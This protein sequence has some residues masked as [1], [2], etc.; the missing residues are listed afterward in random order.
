MPTISELV[1]HLRLHIFARQKSGLNPN[2]S[3]NAIATR[4][5]W[6]FEWSEK[7]DIN[8]VILFTISKSITL[9]VLILG[10]LLSYKMYFEMQW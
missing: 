1:Q 8:F 9:G 2:H 5:R 7:K 3:C 6:A 10:L 4:K